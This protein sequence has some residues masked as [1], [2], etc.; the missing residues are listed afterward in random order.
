MRTKQA[1]HNTTTLIKYTVCAI[2][3]CPSVVIYST[4]SIHS[5]VNAIVV[6]SAVRV[7]DPKGR[8]TGCS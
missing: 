5:S 1:H 6:K 8:H 4:R 3:V 7:R 2:S